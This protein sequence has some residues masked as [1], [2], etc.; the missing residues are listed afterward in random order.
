MY[1]SG[2]VDVQSHSLHHGLIFASDR[3]VDFCTHESR[4]SVDKVSPLLTHVNN[5][6][7]LEWKLPI[8]T[9]LFPMRPALASSWRYLENYNAREKCIAFVEQNGG[10]EFFSIDGWKGA[11][12][13]VYLNSKGV[14]G[15]ET[16]SGRQNRYRN[17]LLSGKQIIEERLHGAKVCAVALPWGAMHQEIPNIARDTGHELC[18][19]AYPFPNQ[20][21]NSPVPLYPRLFGDSIWTLIHGPLRGGYGFWKA[22]K[23]NM[24]RRVSGAIC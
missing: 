16:E 2:L 1:E 14:D 24:I 12:Q 23:R 22:R 10:S 9:P 3:P 4:F 21:W 20:Y 15:W 7:L 6:D 18:V 11:L 8:G 17:D 19:M 13:S 5:K